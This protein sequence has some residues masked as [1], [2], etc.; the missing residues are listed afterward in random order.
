MQKLFFWSWPY[1]FPYSPDEFSVNSMMTGSVFH[2]H[3]MMTSRESDIMDHIF[4]WRKV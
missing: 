4:L 3:L 1:L 2:L